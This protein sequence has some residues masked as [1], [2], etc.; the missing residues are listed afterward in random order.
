MYQLDMANLQYKQELAMQ[1]QAA[2]SQLAQ[3]DSY[4]DSLVGAGQS[5]L[6]TFNTQTAG[7][8]TTQ[9]AFGTAQGPG[10]SAGFIPTGVIN[11]RKDEEDRVSG[12]GGAG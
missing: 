6:N 3:A 12:G 11:R 1:A 4:W 2:S 8:P 7:Q 9:L 10:G 5:G